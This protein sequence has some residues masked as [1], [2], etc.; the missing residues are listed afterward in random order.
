LHEKPHVPPLH[1]G[2]ALATPVVHATGEPHCP[3]A[4]QVSTLVPEQ[5]ACPGAHTPVHAP[6]TH[7]WF[8]HAAAPLQVPLTVQVWTPLPEQVVWLGAHTP[9]Q[10]PETHV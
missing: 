6:L 8:V 3:L 1:V 5:V 7:V 4:A 10:D 9:E 2:D